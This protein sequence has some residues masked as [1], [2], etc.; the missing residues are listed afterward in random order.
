MAD[1]S[2]LRTFDDGDWVLT[3]ARG[4]WVDDGWAAGPR[5][6]RARLAARKAKAI[7]AAGGP[8]PIFRLDLDCAPEARGP[9]ARRAEVVAYGARHGCRALLLQEEGPAGGNPLWA[10]FGTKSALRRLCRAHVAGENP[11]AETEEQSWEIAYLMAGADPAFHRGVTTV[12]EAI[13]SCG[14]CD[15]GEPCTPAVPCLLH[16][17]RVTDILLSSPEAQRAIVAAELRD[18]PGEVDLAGPETEM[19]GARKAEAARLGVP[20]RAVL[21]PEDPEYQEIARQLARNLPAERTA[22]DRDAD[23]ARLVGLDAALREAGVRSVPL[24]ADSPCSHGACPGDRCLP[25]ELREAIAG[26]RLAGAGNVS[27]EAISDED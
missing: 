26:A 16:A 23:A 8:A 6:V 11:T 1:G 19:S 5:D 25:P 10:F 3:D 18:L 27:G 7:A 24:S 9:E 12:A 13:A 2:N 20:A 22:A 17:E 15:A 4:C 14:P 21:L